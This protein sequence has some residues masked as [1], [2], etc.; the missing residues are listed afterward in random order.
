MPIDGQFAEGRSAAR[1]DC[2]RWMSSAPAEPESVRALFLGDV[3]VSLSPAIGGRDVYWDAETTTELPASQG[4]I[5][6][7]FGKRVPGTAGSPRSLRMNMN[8]PNADN[9]NGV[10]CPTH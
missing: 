5:S 3:R 2:W 4:D 10:A 1:F 6:Q 8:V 7:R 9:P